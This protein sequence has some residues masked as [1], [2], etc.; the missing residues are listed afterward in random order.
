M[1]KMTLSLSLFVTQVLPSTVELQ[2]KLNAAIRNDV[3]DLPR[4]LQQLIDGALEVS[5]AIACA[6][7]RL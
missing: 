4:S 7:K 3:R 1:P 2:Q 5:A 6:V